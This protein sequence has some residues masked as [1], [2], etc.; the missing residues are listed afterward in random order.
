M[1][2]DPESWPALSLLLDQWLDL[3]EE[4]RAAWLENLGPEYAGLLPSLRKP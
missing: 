4:S 2:I 3:P 1:K